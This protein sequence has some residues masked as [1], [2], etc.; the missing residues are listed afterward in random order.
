M[1]YQYS[2]GFVLE[3]VCF[4]S[5]FLEGLIG[6]DYSVRVWLLV[7]S[8]NLFSRRSEEVVRL[9][10]SR[11][12][13]SGLADIEEKFWQSEFMILGAL[14]CAVPLKCWIQVCSLLKRIVFEQGYESFLDLRLF[15]RLPVRRRRRVV[16]LISSLCSRLVF[17]G[18][19]WLPSSSL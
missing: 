4:S 2:S 9:L 16:F 17:V 12:V 10:H 14:A 1:D 11:V 13:V 18:L 8:F 5:C 7:C 19:L 6:M 3:L 15:L